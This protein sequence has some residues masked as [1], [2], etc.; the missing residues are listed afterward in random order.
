MFIGLDST[1][2]TFEKLDPTHE[3][4]TPDFFFFFGKIVRIDGLR[5]PFANLDPTSADYADKIKEACRQFA[6]DLRKVSEKIG[7]S[8]TSALAL[9]NHLGRSVPPW[10]SG[11]VTP[12][13]ARDFFAGFDALIARLDSEPSDVKFESRLASKVS[14]QLSVV[15]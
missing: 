4:F 14:K 12:E 11:E 9:T 8:N 1:L 5:N 6:K 2:S 7:T 15:P 3:I 13:M 10:R